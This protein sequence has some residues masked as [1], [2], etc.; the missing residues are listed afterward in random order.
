[1]PKALLIYTCGFKLIILK[2]K[3]I[4]RHCDSH[5][6]QWRLTGEV[7]RSMTPFLIAKLLIAEKICIDS[8]FLI[9]L[10]FFQ[11]FLEDN[12]FSRQKKSESYVW[13][14]RV[15]YIRYIRCGYFQF[16]SLNRFNLQ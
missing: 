15:A 12:A 11:D 4:R 14:P 1:M 5:A 8:I 7:Q 9:F 16:N 6:S 13:M 10:N 3:P 2:L